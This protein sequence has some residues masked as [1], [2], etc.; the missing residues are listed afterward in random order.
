MYH[1]TNEFR[2]AFI[3]EVPSIIGLGAV[4]I[5][6]VIRVHGES[7]AAAQPSQLEQ[8]GAHDIYL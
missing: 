6:V 4:A 3:P 5:I 7:R 8:H 2:R 1:S